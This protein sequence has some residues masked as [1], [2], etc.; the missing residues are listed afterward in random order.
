MSGKNAENIQQARLFFE[1]LGRKDID[2]WSRLWA[3]DGKILVFYP[4]EGFG[5]SIEGKAAIV[6]AFRALF[7]NFESFESTITAVYDSADMNA[8]VVEY[9]NRAILRG[10]TEYTNSNI[11]VFRFE[12]G[13]IAA[14]HDY[15]DP[16]RFQVVIDALR[17]IHG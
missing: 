10:G 6:T 14:Y 5:S 11:A 3:E 16:R 15:F 4:P 17:Q 8:V 1:L 7:G 13:L 2:A 12:Q 9:R